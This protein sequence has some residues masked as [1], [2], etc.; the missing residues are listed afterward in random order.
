MHSSSHASLISGW[1]AF[2]LVACSGTPA[3]T[4]TDVVDGGSRGDAAPEAAVEDPIPAPDAGPAPSPSPSPTRVGGAFTAQGATF[5]VSRTVKGEGVL[6]IAFA[7]VDD[8]CRTSRTEAFTDVL[9]VTLRSPGAPA[10]GAFAIVPDTVMGG[11]GPAPQGTA[12]L[13][14]VY[15]V[16][17]DLCSLSNKNAAA[18][19]TVT[20]TKVTADTLEGTVDSTLQTG[21]A[22]VQGT[23]EATRCD[24]PRAGAFSCPLTP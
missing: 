18:S 13:W 23:F 16:G 15:D 7:D 8:V 6:D 1:V 9:H 21:S 19:G 2:A 3:S 24:T 14:S 17:S 22:K 12:V 5:R 4:R 10:P 11:S 20:L